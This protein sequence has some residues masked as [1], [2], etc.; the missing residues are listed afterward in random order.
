[1]GIG[2]FLRQWKEEH[3]FFYPLICLT[4]GLFVILRGSISYFV[5]IEWLDI[6]LIPIFLIYLLARDQEFR[7]CCLAFFMGILTDIVAPCQLGLF[8]LAYSTVIL[9]INRCRQLLDFKDIKTSIL[10]VAVFLLARWAFLLIALRL[11]PTGQF[12][13]SISF[14]SVF[15]STLITSLITPLL[16]YCLDL[17]GGTESFGHAQKGPVDV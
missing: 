5:R 16:F 14:V 7:S 6:D 3:V 11:F 10:F 9:G 2:I 12:I 17:A 4:C 1:M 15:I 13:P 8:A